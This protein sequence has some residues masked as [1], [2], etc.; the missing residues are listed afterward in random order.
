M[1]LF[2]PALR[3][4]WAALN[5]T[6]KLRELSTDK[7]YLYIKGRDMRIIMNV[8]KNAKV[9]GQVI[10]EV[11]PKLVEL[12][13]IWLAVLKKLL[14]NSHCTLP[15]TTSSPTRLSPRTRSK[16]RAFNAL[17]AEAERVGVVTRLSKRRLVESIAEGCSIPSPVIGELVT[18]TTD[19][20]AE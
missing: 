16:K 15:T 18:L 17:Q 14:G 11:R 6:N 10:I 20:G 3:N 8:F 4:D 12:L 19:E 13:I 2:Q 1:Y 9:M 7:N 5:I